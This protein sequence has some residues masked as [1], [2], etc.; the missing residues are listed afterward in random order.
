MVRDSCRAGYEPSGT[1][2]TQT[3]TS[4]D[5]GGPFVSY[6]VHVER[7]DVYGARCM[8]SPVERCP[9]RY[10]EVGPGKCQQTL[11]QAASLA[12]ECSDDEAVLAGSTCTSYQY[13]TLVE[14]CPAGFQEV[15]PGKCQA[16]VCSDAE[17]VLNGSTCTSYLYAI[18]RASG[19][20]RGI[21]K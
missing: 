18:S 15:G 13:A 8:R 6:R 4:A 9:A 14:R 5:D 1:T 21:R 17:A 11:T 10:Q 20:R 2:C 16:H 19:V 3:V 7:V 12:Y